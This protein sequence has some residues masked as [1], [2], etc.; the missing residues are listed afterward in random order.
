VLGSP[1]LAAC[2]SSS[3]TSTSSSSSG[4][5]GGSKDF[6]AYNFQLSWIKNVEFAG[7]Y[8]ADNKGYYKDAGFSSVN[9]ITGG[10]LVKQDANVASQSGGAFIGTSDPVI[11]AAAINQGAKLIVVG[12]QYQKSP[13]C[14]MSRAADGMPNPAAMKG[15]RIGVQDTNLN[16]WNAF[17]AVNNL[18]Q[19]DVT[20]VSVQFD[21]SELVASNPTVDGWFSFITNEPIDLKKKGHDTITFLLSDYGL[22]LASQHYIVNTDALKENR[23]KIKAALLGEIRG[24]RDSLVDPALGAHLAATV[25][26]KDQNLDEAEQTD[27]SKAQNDLILNADTRANGIFT[28]TDDLVGKTIDS[29]GKAGQTI[30]KEKL[31]DLSLIKEVYEEHPD[32]KTAPS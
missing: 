11:T 6:G 4:A 31:Y 15:R 8:I 14:I 3:K 26:G 19:S 12:A 18:K 24:W 29:L 30:T 17:L 27:E 25:Y 21:P 20:T 2:S 10:P 23:D 9:L 7:M 32:L 1:L 5:G 16:I 13:F 22:P 28:I